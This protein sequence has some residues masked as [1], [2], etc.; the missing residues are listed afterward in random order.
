MAGRVYKASNTCVDVEF[1]VQGMLANNVY[2]VGNETGLLAV[3]PSDDADEIVEVLAGRKLDAIVITHGHNDHMGAA[4]ALREKTGAP[5][6]ASALDAP[7]IVAPEALSVT[8]PARPCPVDRTVEDGDV[9]EVGNVKWKVL[10]TPGHTPGSMCLYADAAEMG[11]PE[12]GNVLMSGDTLF[13]RSTGRTDFPGGSDADM[14]ASMV[15]L[16]QLPD[17]TLVCPGHN[18][19]TVIEAERR[20]AFA[21]WGV[22]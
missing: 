14:R 10:L 17:E 1:V 9:V 2:L 4:A 20:G 21:M 19:L 5:V 22:L 12:L 8:Q 3:D 18:N 11:T 13:C 6:I 15:R 16:S 7:R